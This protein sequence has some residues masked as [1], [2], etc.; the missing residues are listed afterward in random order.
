MSVISTKN[1]ENN[2]QYLL[3]F[4]ISISQIGLEIT[5]IIEQITTR[6]LFLSSN[7]K[8][9][10]TQITKT[11]ITTTE[12]NQISSNKLIDFIKFLKADFSIC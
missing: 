4:E 8:S 1:R 11:R 10:N 2:V 12:I 5:D 6:V 7:I 3:C 9:G